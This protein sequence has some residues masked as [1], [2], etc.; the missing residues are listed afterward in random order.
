MT[1]LSA[2]YLSLKRLSEIISLP[3]RVTH[4]I[5]ASGNLPSYEHGRNRLV[6]TL[7]ARLLQWLPQADLPTL[8]ELLAKNLITEGALFTHLGPCFGKG[9]APAAYRFY[10]GKAIKNMPLLYAK[11]D[12]FTEGGRIEIP[13]HPENFI[14]DSSWEQ[15]SG[16]RRLFLLGRITGSELPH[17]KAQAYVIGHLYDADRPEAE[18]LDPFG[19][20]SERM[21]VFPPMIDHFRGI[22]EIRGVSKKELDGLRGISEWDIKEAFAEIIGE[23]FVPRDWGGER[24]DLFSARVSLGGRAVST[25]FIFKGP[26]KFKPLTVAD[27]GKN[28]D[29]ISRLFTEP[30]QFVVLQHCHQITAGVRDHMRAFATRIH[31]LRPFS[32]IDGADTVRILKV[33][34][35]LGYRV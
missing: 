3:D 14:T 15:L 11:L 24:S 9:V 22:S 5:M 32:L 8:G 21:E 10:E 30:A 13:L 18:T 34:G 2:L 23:P 31:D 7:E 19:R 1:N 25:A 27:L 6:V 16:Q 26:S 4:K 17:L 20:L 12:S 35:K 28:G 29:Q 33:H